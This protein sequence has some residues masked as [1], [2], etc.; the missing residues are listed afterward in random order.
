VMVY[1]S[2]NINKP[3]ESFNSDGLQI[4][5]YQQKERKFKH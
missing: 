1:N 2:T 5:Q 3:R 4:H